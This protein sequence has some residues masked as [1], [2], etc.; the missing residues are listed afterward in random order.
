MAKTLF[1][2]DAYLVEIC[3]E[4]HPRY[5]YFLNSLEYWKN[6]FGHTRHPT[7]DKGFIQLL[8]DFAC[9]EEFPNPTGSDN[10]DD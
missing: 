3:P 2:T 7:H 5:R 4:S 1:L 8:S 9:Q 10:R 6:L